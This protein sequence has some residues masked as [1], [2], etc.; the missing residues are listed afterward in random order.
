MTETRS[1]SGSTATTGKKHQTDKEQPEAKKA[2]TGAK[3]TTVE[4]AFDKEEEEDGGDVKP[5]TEDEGEGEGA[6]KGEESGRKPGEEGDDAVKPGEEGDMPSNILEKGIIYFFVRGRVGIDN[7]GG[8][9]D[10]ARSYLLLRPIE[11]D[12]KLGDGPIGDA[13][14]S[15]LLALPKKVLPLSGKDRFMAFVEKAGASFKDVKDTFLDGSDYTTKTAGVRHTPP[16]KPAGEGIYAITSTGRESH[17]AY[18]LTLPEEPKD[19]QADLGLR[20]KGSFILSTKNPQYSGPTFAQLPKSPE[21]P[22]EYDICPTL[23]RP[24]VH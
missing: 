20:E 18:I 13:G 6:S 15:R 10:V 2:K 24:R 22:D 16:A 9:G 5:K 21:Y 1:Q 12:A 17:L 8:V 23:T 7:P 19:F 14:N 4:Q 3:Q 11:K